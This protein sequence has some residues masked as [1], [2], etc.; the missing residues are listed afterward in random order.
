MKEKH[1]KLRQTLFTV[2]K[3]RFSSRDVKV[4][5][6]QNQGENAKRQHLIQQKLW[7]HKYEHRFFKY[8]DVLWLSHYLSESNGSWCMDEAIRDKQ[9]MS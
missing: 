6:W 7:R 3:Y 8:L 4:Q 1:L 5:S 2:F 9:K